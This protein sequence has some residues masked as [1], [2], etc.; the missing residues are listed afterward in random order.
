MSDSNDKIF[1][2]VKFENTFKIGD[3]FISMLMSYAIPKAVQDLDSYWRSDGAEKVITDETFGFIW[4]NYPET[5]GELLDVAYSICSTST[6]IKSVTKEFGKTFIADL[7]QHIE[8][9]EDIEDNRLRIRLL[10]IVNPNFDYLSHLC[11]FALDA[12]KE[13]LYNLWRSAGLE[14]S[15][16]SSF[17]DYLWSKVKREKGSVDVK[18]S[19]LTAAFENDAVS[20]ALLKKISKSSPKNIK[21]LAT[22]KF[23]RKIQTRRRDVKR[24]KRSEDL[25]MA[26]FMQKRVDTLEKKIMLFVDCIDREVVSNLFDC[27][28]KDNLPWLMPAASHHYWLAERLQSKLDSNTE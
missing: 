19:I 8:Y 7:Y 23:S 5:R 6:R 1:N 28:S 4:E 22:D 18:L 27:L 3:D 12:E 11:K 21:R 26:A 16:D 15:K 25:E 2:K 10:P 14:S 24:Y 13:N 20:D 9:N 17:Y